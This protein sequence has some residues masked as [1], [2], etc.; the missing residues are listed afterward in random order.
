MTESGDSKNEQG[1]SLGNFISS[2]SNFVSSDEYIK[3]MKSAKAK[4]ASNY[5]V[6][7]FYSDAPVSMP[8]WV[9]WVRLIC[10]HFWRHATFRWCVYLAPLLVFGILASSGVFDNERLRYSES[11]SF[12]RG[13]IADYSTLIW[14]FIFVLPTVWVWRKPILKLIGFLNKSAE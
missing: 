4:R 8:K 11:W 14:I 7:K 1:N 6:S 9:Q 10:F 2:Q 3:E 12:G 13:N 5:E